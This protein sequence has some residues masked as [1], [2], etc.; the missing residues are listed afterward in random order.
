VFA[1]LFLI[2]TS[3]PALLRD[4]YCVVTDLNCYTLTARC[5]LYRLIVQYWD[6]LPVALQQWSGL[7]PL[8]PSL[9][10]RLAY[11]LFP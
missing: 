8:Y 7:Q 3:R 2:G 11:R 5:W 10:C 1:P 4:G 6:I 9:F